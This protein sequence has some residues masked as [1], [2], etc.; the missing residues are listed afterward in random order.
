MVH[1]KR[2]TFI[3]KRQTWIKNLRLH[4]VKMEYDDW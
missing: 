1:M 2:K 3:D 4:I